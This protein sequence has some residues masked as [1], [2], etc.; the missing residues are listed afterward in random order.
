MRESASKCNIT[1]FS[2][3]IPMALVTRGELPH[4]SQCVIKQ[5]IILVLNVCPCVSHLKTLN[6]AQLSYDQPAPNPLT[7]LNR[8]SHPFSFHGYQS[9][10]SHLCGKHHISQ[11]LYH[12]IYL[13]LT[14]NSLIQLV[15]LLLGID[16]LAVQ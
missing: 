14:L 3:A 1:P 10:V 6:T 12:P 15:E 2:S 16:G 7:F 8:E 4:H 5:S 11:L 9:K 13:L